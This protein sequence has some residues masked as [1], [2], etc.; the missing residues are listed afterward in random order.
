[1]HRRTTFSIVILLVHCGSAQVCHEICL[2]DGPLRNLDLEVIRDLPSFRIINS[3]EKVSDNSESFRDDATDLSRMI[4]R[5]G[6]FDCELNNA[7]A[8]K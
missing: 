2:S 3:V 1:M 5:L 7:N 6:E 8:T 4:S